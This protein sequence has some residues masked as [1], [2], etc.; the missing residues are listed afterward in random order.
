M[1][2]ML[3]SY[4][5]Y[6]CEDSDLIQFGPTLELRSELRNTYIY[7]PQSIN[8]VSVELTSTATTVF[9]LAFILPFFFLTSS[10]ISFLLL[11][12]LQS[13]RVA[14]I[15]TGP[16]YMPSRKYVDF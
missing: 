11:N 10:K 1:N 8:Y 4:P 9:I 7:R 16:S 13:F 12:L 15:N 14:T 2:Y 3:I 6:L 5:I